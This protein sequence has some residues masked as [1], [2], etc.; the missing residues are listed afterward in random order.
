MALNP[1]FWPALLAAVWQAKKKAATH[2]TSLT[3]VRQFGGI[4][5]VPLAVLDSTIIPTFGSLDLLTAW[6]AVGDPERWWY[7]AL[8]STAGSL[9]GA[10][11]TYRMG[12]KMGEWW[13]ERKIGRRHLQ[14][15]HDAIDRRGS[16]AIFV[17]TIA[18]PPFPGPWFFIVAGALALPRKKFAAA[19]LLGR[20][21][22]YG[23]VTL[24]AAHYG[25]VFLRYLRHPLHYVLISVIVTAS[26]I[27]AVILF[28]MR[29][30]TPQPSASTGA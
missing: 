19:A 5:L 8:M 26:L 22:R 9:I 17:A 16:G 25:R 7:Y 20:A 4:A 27:A 11:I 18:P 28:G 6:L 3:L 21:L 10:L 14:Q 23:L 13:I 15:L 12:A 29:R 2:S 30:S 24:V 1:N